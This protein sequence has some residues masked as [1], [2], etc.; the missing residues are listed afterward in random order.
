[1]LRPAARSRAG[2]CALCVSACRPCFQPATV[3]LS[4]PSNNQYS[5]CLRAPRRW[6]VSRALIH[7]SLDV[8]LVLPSHPCCSAVRMASVNVTNIAVF[9]NPCIFTTG[10][11]FEVTFE[12]VA[13]LT[14]G[15]RTGCCDSTLPS[16]TAARSPIASAAAKPCSYFTFAICVRCVRPCRPRMEGDLRRVSVWAAVRSRA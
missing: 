12:C 10:F 2:R 8:S 4:I 9:D 5:V 11:R 13:P 14:E 15:E 7:F 6:D 1:M 16:I 3:R